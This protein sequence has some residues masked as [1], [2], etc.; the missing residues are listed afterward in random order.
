MD[1]LI[2]ARRPDLVMVKN[3]N[4]KKENLSNSGLS[5]SNWPEVKLKESEKRDKY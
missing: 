3:N 1:H 4:K 5:R 2:S